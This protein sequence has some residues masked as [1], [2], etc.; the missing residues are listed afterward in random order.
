MFKWYGDP[1]A[2]IAGFR[3]SEIDVA[4]DLQDSDL[5]KVQDL[6]DQVAAIPA[7]LYEFLRPNWSPADAVHDRRPNE[8]RR[9]LAQRRRSR[10]AARAARQPTRR[11]ARPSPTRSTRTRSTRAS[12]AA[13][14]RSR[15]RTSARR[16][17][18]TRT[19][20]RSTFD[21]DKA[22]QILADGGW[23]DSDGDGIV[24]KDGTKAK[25]ELCTTTRQVRQD[26]LA[27]ISSWLKDVGIDSVINPVAPSDIFA[28][29][30]E[31]TI[32]TPCDPR[33]EQLRRR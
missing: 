1:D 31:A 25:I 8:H 14:P 11:S 30:N 22:K 13:T 21:P 9:L 5:P 32:D 18:S 29:Y 26:T 16:R 23:A 3:N 33:P 17:G 27:L 28:D 15:T 6:G 4:F 12:S 7:L 2:M 10:T 24:E 20:R 19:S